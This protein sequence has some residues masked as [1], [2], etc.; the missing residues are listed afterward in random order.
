MDF[1]EFN[2]SFKAI[3]IILLFACLIKFYFSFLCIINYS[4]NVIF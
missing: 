2:A 1:A 4:H 3:L